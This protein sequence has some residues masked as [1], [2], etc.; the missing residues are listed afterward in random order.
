MKAICEIY[1]EIIV[2]VD[3]NRE[4]HNARRGA[5]RYEATT[6]NLECAANLGYAEKLGLAAVLTNEQ[7]EGMAGES[8]RNLA[9]RL[10]IAKIRFRPMLPMGRGKDAERERWQL[11]SEELEVSEDFCLRY[12][13]GLGQNLYV[14]PNGDTYPCYAW[15]ATDKKLGNLNAETLGKLL[16]RREL[17]EYCRHDVDTNEK[18]RTCEV[19]YICGG[20]CKAWVNNKD[21]VDSGNFDCS[22]RKEYY[23]KVA[24][25]IKNR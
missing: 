9:H 10:H 1:D 18:C 21:N 4:T 5:G 16:D 14:E 6:T 8:V 24:E 20:I 17:F 23:L 13:C 25:K 19:R 15:C 7:I 3:G 11:C 2:S 22:S 12:T